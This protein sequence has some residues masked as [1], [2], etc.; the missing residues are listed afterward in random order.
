MN[1]AVIKVSVQ[2]IKDI[3]QMAL[4]HLDNILRALDDNIGE[5]V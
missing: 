3:L 1:K 5:V 2:A 4:L